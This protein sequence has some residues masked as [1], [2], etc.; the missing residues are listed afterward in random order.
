MRGRKDGLAG[1]PKKLLAIRF[2]LLVF[3]TQY[4]IPKTHKNR[5]GNIFREKGEKVRYF[6]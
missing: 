2:W 5:G 3:K 1:M 4:P 6:I